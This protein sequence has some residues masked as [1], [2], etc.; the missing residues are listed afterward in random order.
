M[1]LQRLTGLERSKVESEYKETIK[2][3][4]KLK[5]I[6]RSKELQKELIHEELL[7]LKEK[8]GDERRT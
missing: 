2:L 3:I 1:R 6:L 7:K 4:E 8:Y 5:S